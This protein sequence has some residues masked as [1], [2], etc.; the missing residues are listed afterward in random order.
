M[1]RCFTLYG[2]AFLEV[3]VGS[4]IRKLIMEKVVIEVDPARGGKPSKDVVKNADLLI[5]WCKEIWE[6]IFAA[7]ESCPKQVRKI[8]T[9][10]PS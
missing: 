4:T 7:K 5:S 1:E 10:I 3:S 8:C 9:R 2:S 6:Q